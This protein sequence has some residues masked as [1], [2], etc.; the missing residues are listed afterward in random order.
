MPGDDVAESHLRYF[1]RVRDQTGVCRPEIA[2]Q[3]RLDRSQLAE[4]WSDLL[5]DPSCRKVI[6]KQPKAAPFPNRPG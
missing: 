6:D 3:L 2:F 4:R 5:Q 1:F